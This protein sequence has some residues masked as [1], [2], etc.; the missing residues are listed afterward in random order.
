MGLLPNKTLNSNPAYFAKTSDSLSISSGPVDGRLRQSGIEVIKYD[1]N[2]LFFHRLEKPIQTLVRF[3][4]DM[5]TSKP[6]EFDQENNYFL[7]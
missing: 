1:L 4:H 2:L 7:N 3:S 5:K 6:M